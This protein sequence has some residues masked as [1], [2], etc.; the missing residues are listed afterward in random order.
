M[1]YDF[2]SILARLRSGVQGTVS[3]LEGTFAGDLLQSVAAELARIWSQEVD[4]AAQRGFLATAEG[5]WLDAVCGDY[6]ITRKSGESDEGL[7]AR[8]LEQVRSR[9]GG[10]TAADYVGW[11]LALEGVAAASAVPLAR[12]AGTVNVYFVPAADAPE[13]LDG[14]V[15]AALEERRPVGADVRAIR[16]QSTA[17]NVSA[18][19]TLAAGS[20]LD[21]VKSGFSQAMETWLEAG[22]TI[23][24][25]TQVPYEGS[26]MEVYQ[27]GYQV[28]EKYQLMEAYNMTLEAATAK[29][30]WALGQTR[31]SGQVRQLFEQPVQFDLIR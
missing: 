14:Q 27:V 12:G 20:A 21:Q 13:G 6:G 19:V 2:D 8:A 7:R 22:K 15:S 29:L 24:M 5:Q 23:V 18:A 1:K 26:D 11:T 30:M 28:K 9:G 10:G 3:T 17:V 25:M 31:E 4:T 16:A